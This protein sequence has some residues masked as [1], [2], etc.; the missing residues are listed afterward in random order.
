LRPGLAWGA[1]TNDAQAYF[2]QGTYLVRLKH[3]LREAVPVIY[4]AAVSIR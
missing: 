1:D 2:D 3:V 4:W